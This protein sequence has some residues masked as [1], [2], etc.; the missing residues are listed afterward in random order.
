MRIDP[1]FYH[2]DEIQLFPDRPSNRI[3]NR[4]TTGNRDRAIFPD[5]KQFFRLADSSVSV[6]L[7]AIGCEGQTVSR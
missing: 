1:S 5:R 4:D 6:H 2:T 7:C 3:L